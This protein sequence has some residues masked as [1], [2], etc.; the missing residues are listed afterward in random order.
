MTATQK[1]L[2]HP[3]RRKL[4][5][6]LHTRLP[7]LFVAMLS[8]VKFVSFKAGEPLGPPTA[9]D[10]LLS[11]RVLQQH[12]FLQDRLPLHCTH[13][14]CASF[15]IHI[16]RKRV[17][18]STQTAR[19]FYE[20][21]HLF[22]RKAFDIYIICH[23]CKYSI[24]R[25]HCGFFEIPIGSNNLLEQFIHLQY[26]TQEVFFALLLSLQSALQRIPH[27]ASNAGRHCF[28]LRASRS[29]LPF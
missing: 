14:L 23:S 24:L 25:D 27:R 22:M 19:S 4:F 5:I 16:G 18:L 26:H 1:S 6:E 2:L 3:R 20:T 15:F 11:P 21:R 12:P 17:R 7:V 9:H 13:F 28:L 29:Q 8:T 10:H